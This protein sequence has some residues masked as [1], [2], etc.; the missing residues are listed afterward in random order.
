ML[1]MYCTHIGNLFENT[2]QKNGCSNCILNFYLKT[3]KTSTRRI[4]RSIAYLPFTNF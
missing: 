3:A 1:S 4:N 2:T